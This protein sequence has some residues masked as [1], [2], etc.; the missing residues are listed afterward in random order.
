MAN[1]DRKQKIV[2]LKDFFGASYICKFSSTSTSSFHFCWPI[3]LQRLTINFMLDTRWITGW[4][5]PIA[6]GEIKRY[7]V[8]KYKFG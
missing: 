8:S 7:I 5:R 6:A 4:K 2:L 1:P 3:I